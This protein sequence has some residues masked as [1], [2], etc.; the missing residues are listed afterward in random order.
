MLY[1]L[2]TGKHAFPSDSPFGAVYAIVTN[3]SAAAPLSRC[4]PPRLHSLILAMLA[5]NPAARPSAD[6]VARK[7]GECILPAREP[8]WTA[9]WRK[10]QFWLAVLA[11]FLVMGAIGWFLFHKRDSPQF[12]DLSIQALTSQGGWESSPALSPD[13]Q[14]IAFTWSDKLDGSR[15]IY[16]KQFGD[17]EPVKLTN[18]ESEG[19][20][21]H[22]VWSPDGKRIAFKRGY[23]REPGAVYSIASTGG[24]ARKILDLSSVSL[25]SAIDWSADGKQLAFSDVLPGSNRFAIYLFNLRTGEKRKL[26]SPPSD[27]WGDWDPKFSPDDL[28]MAFK[29]VTDFWVDDIY[30]I[31]TAVGPGPP[32]RPRTDAGSGGHAW[33]PDGRNLIVSCQRRSTLFALWRFPLMPR[34]Q[35]ERITQVG[36]DAITPTTGR[37]SDR[38]G[39]VNQRWDLNIDRVPMSGIGAPT[40][41]IASTL[42]DQGAIYSLD[43]RIAFIS[44]RSGSREI[45]ARKGG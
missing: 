21:G 44:D 42:R 22:L 43:G 3:E 25:S 1:E 5:K 32:V 35:P 6:E 26:T 39:W 23:N 15:Q 30:V 29:R 14:S 4:V 12:A 33:L 34:T 11:L 36:I 45:W 10:S 2:A 7:L 41:L 13:G 17:N 16:L 27:I 24:D 37:K 8:S 38:L 28:T 20:I 18:F 40:K 31:P 9:A 19:N